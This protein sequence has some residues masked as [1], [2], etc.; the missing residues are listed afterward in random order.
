[1]E[2]ANFVDSMK[3]LYP[4]PNPVPDFYSQILDFRRT[5]D[6]NPCFSDTETCS[7]INAIIRTPVSLLVSL[8][9]RDRGVGV[10][11]FQT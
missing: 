4:Y 5:S 3:F 8:A 1:M 11:Y 10:L 6:Y 2:T 9:L 7:D